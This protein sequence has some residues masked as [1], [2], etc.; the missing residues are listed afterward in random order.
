[1][2]YH[3][4]SQL[5]RARS[6][7]FADIPATHEAFS[8]Y[9]E[10]K[11]LELFAAVAR[12]CAVEL[13]EKPIQN[14][15]LPKDLQ[16]TLFHFLSTMDPLNNL[17]FYIPCLQLLQILLSSSL[18]IVP[19]HLITQLC[20]FLGEIKTYEIN[21]IIINVSYALIDALYHLALSRRK[22]SEHQD[23]AWIQKI[24]LSF[25]GLFNELLSKPELKD[26]AQTEYCLSDTR[27]SIE[28]RV[29]RSNM[30]TDMILYIS[31]ALSK[32][33]KFLTNTVPND[34][35]SQT[36]PLYF[37]HIVNEFNNRP[38]TEIFGVQ[39]GIC[40]EKSIAAFS[41]LN[42]NCALT[43]KL[44]T[45]RHF[46]K[47][48]ADKIR[49]LV[50]FCVLEFYRNKIKT[51]SCC[52]EDDESVLGRLFMQIYE[53]VSNYL[54]H[55]ELEAFPLLLSSIFLQTEISELVT[56]LE[57]SL[58]AFTMQF[59]YKYLSIG[60]KK[61]KL[62]D[63]GLIGLLF[64]NN[65]FQIDGISEIGQAAKETWD[66]I[67]KYLSADTGNYEWISAAV[68]RQ[69]KLNQSDITYL[70]KMNGWIHEQFESNPML[71]EL[72]ISNGLL[73]EMFE[74]IVSLHT[75]SKNSEFLT[76]F[77][78]MV[79]SIICMYDISIPSEVSEKLV[80]LMLQESLIYD[81]SISEYVL[82]CLF[83]LMRKE[84]TQSY[85]R[86]VQMLKNGKTFDVKKRLLEG[87]QDILKDSFY[88]KT[89]Q[90]HFLKAG[91]LKILREILEG[92]FEEEQTDLIWQSTMECVRFVIQDNSFS[93]E[94]FPELGID[95]LAKMISDEKN[96]EKRPEICNKVI[97]ILLLILFDCRNL[98][99]AHEIVN[100]K[101]IPLLLTMLCYVYNDFSH[102]TLKML[103]KSYNAGIFSMNSAVKILVEGLKHS[104]NPEILDFIQKA[105]SKTCGFH[106]SPLD[107]KYVM[108]IACGLNLDKQLMLFD[109]LNEGISKCFIRNSEDNNEKS[110]KFLLD[111]CN[112]ILFS[113]G[114]NTLR[115]EA[116]SFDFLPKKDFTIVLQVFIEK[117]KSGTIL[118]FF[119][120]K[121]EFTVCVVRKSLE[122]VYMC[123]KK[124]QFK[125]QTDKVIRKGEWNFICICMQLW[126]K[127]I[128]S[129]SSL[130][131]IVNGKICGK[132]TEG[133]IINIT[134]GFNNLSLGN[135]SD[136]SQSFIGRLRFFVILNKFL[137]DFQFVTSIFDDLHLIFTPEP[138]SIHQNL[139]KVP[140][141]LYKSVHFHYFTHYTHIY[142]ENIKIIKNAVLFNGTNIIH[143]LA[144]LGGLPLIV[145][146]IHD[147]LVDNSLILKIL[148]FVEIFTRASSLEIL[149]PSDFFEML[150][151]MLENIVVP[152]E[153]LL[154]V[155]NAMLENLSWKPQYREQVFFS[156]LCNTEFWSNLPSELHT[157]YMSIISQHIT[158]HIQCKLANCA[159]LYSHIMSLSPSHSSYLTD[160]FTR[161]LPRGG[162][163][164]NS[165]NLDAVAFLLFK[166]IRDCPEAMEMFLEELS[167]VEIDKKCTSDLIFLILHFMEWI[168]TPSVQAGVLRVVKGIMVSMV[169]EG[170]KARKNPLP[171][172]IL[173]FALN[174]IDTKLDKSLSL[175]IFQ[176]LMDIVIYS[177]TLA[178]T[179]DANFFIMFIDII[180]KRF[181]VLKESVKE[182]LYKATSDYQFC[183]MIVERENFPS[184]LIEAYYTE[185]DSAVSLGLKFFAHSS[186]NM[187][188]QKLRHFVLA[189][190]KNE[191]NSGL[192]FYKQV[193]HSVMNDKFIAEGPRFLDFCSI[194][195]DILNPEV[196][197]KGE[198]NI[199]LLTSVINCLIQQALDLSFV[200]CTYPPLPRMD[201]TLQ[202]ELLKQ[203]PLELSKTEDYI[204]LKEGGFLRLALKY[205]FIGLQISP[206]PALL[207]LLKTVLNAGLNTQNFL[208]LDLLGK[209]IS[210]K[211]L[212]DS[213]CERY[214]ITYSK[215]PTRETELM[216][217]EEFLY[218]YILTELTE[219]VRLSND[220]SLIVF[221]MNFLQD[222][223]I[224]KTLVAWGKKITNK[225]LEDFYKM[226][227]EYKFLFFPNSRSRSPQME[228]NSVLMLMNKL[229]PVSL[230]VFQTHISEQSEML[231]KAKTS[232][233]MLKELFSSTNWLM[234]VYIYIL[235]FTSMKLNFVSGLV[236]SHII[237]PIKNTE[238]ILSED[239]TYKLNA[240]IITKQE[241]LKIWHG[242]FKET[243][244]RLKFVFHQKFVNTTNYFNKTQNAFEKGKVKLR[245]NMDLLSRM[246]TCVHQRHKER[247]ST[248]RSKTISMPTE[249]RF[250][251]S[252]II[253]TSTENSIS[254]SVDESEKGT[255][256][257]EPEE[258]LAENVIIEKKKTVKVEC[259][260]IKVSYSLYGDLEVAQDYILFISEGKEKP[261]EGKYFGSALKFTQEQKKQAKFFIVE[262]IAEVFHRRFIHKH[263][264]FEV[265]LK[266][267]KSLFFNVFTSETRESVFEVIKS[268]KH[269]RLISEIC[270]SYLKSIT[271]KWKRCL[272]SNLE[273]LMI[274]NKFASRSFNDISQYPIFPW[275]LKDYHSSELRL[276]DQHMYRNF[277][278]PIGAQNDSG[279]QEADRRFSMWI[280]EQPYHFGS[281]YS[282]G[283]IVL[284][285]LVRLEP[286]ST[287]AKILQ[288]GKFDIADRLFHSI[289]A[290]WES[291]QG[292][293]GDVKELVP[294]MFYLPEILVNINEEDFGAKQD[295]EE[296]DCVELPRWASSPIDFIRKHR[297]AL[298]SNYVS[299]NINNW[300]DLVFGYKQKG[301]QAQNSYNLFCPMTYEDNFCKM[302]ESSAESEAMMQGMVDQVVHF[303]QTPIRL[304]KSPHTTRDPKPVDMNIFDKYRKF[305]ECV[306]NGCETN[307]EI[308]AL[309]VTTKFL[310]LIKNVY[311]RISAIRI[312]LN[313][314]DNNRVVFERKKE[315]I[316]QG[317]QP[318][319]P[320]SQEFY[321]T[322][323]ENRLVSGDQIDKSFKIHSL[324]G[325]LEA[326]VFGHTDLV[327]S[328]FTI[329]DLL[330]TG[331][332][333]SSLFS[334]SEVKSQDKNLKL[335]L[336]SRFLGH[337]TSIVMIRGLENYQMVFSLGQNG[338][339]LIH[340]FRSSDC[341]KGIKTSAIG[342]CLS[343]LGIIGIYTHTH[344]QFM[345]INES[346]ISKKRFTID[347]GMFDNS[348][349]N[350][351]YFY[352]CTWGFFS[353]FDE[354][355]RFEK[356]EEL[357][358]V[359]LQLPVENEYFIFSQASEKLSYAITF[360]L[361]YKESFRVVRRH[362]IL[363]D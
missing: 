179:E 274:L 43:A 193:L 35:F 283:A 140:K 95:A 311:G 226:V 304:F 276:E 1:M 308:C 143:S 50:F 47:Y 111:T 270:C 109:G 18:F 107:L 103:E 250:K 57:P 189:I 263:T 178:S 125:V 184:W 223:N 41:L 170:K 61:T 204:Y 160:F 154:E 233:A 206:A 230:G 8:V 119:E 149:I 289:Q 212:S 358:L 232:Q 5:S 113:G 333:D 19:S 139:D 98:E 158:S 132:K 60:L 352:G 286:F 298:E 282:S 295:D 24:F 75:S 91:L 77:F 307:G 55:S 323:G 225:E 52:F 327:S 46:V 68:V 281:H 318:S 265:F 32:L 356:T 84:N 210:D 40:F 342:I 217:T 6:M 13:N 56:T 231:T 220:E 324:N 320:S 23:S 2:A 115:F 63:C 319:R 349:E 347:K 88:K 105:L 299:Q 144:L 227:S 28:S 337:S 346:E 213:Q 34:I 315:K 353:L 117:S 151:S 301:K 90:V 310:I 69:I 297:L 14:F 136:C 351:Y 221:A 65:F 94:K 332:I 291:G 31:V 146:I 322:Y 280:D 293:N 89:C 33:A 167:L 29:I 62:S 243:E 275:V 296:V 256:I 20:L 306:S 180:T 336:A 82:T 199:E 328:V 37:Q 334:W 278:L 285:Y 10:H 9:S 85:N 175:E 72:Y 114:K 83:L 292:I 202:Y 211:L 74:G 251:A 317:C 165:E 253:T 277:K 267:G 101:I 249:Q 118:S 145:S 339:I 7:T 245:W 181:A 39:L 313:E 66:L 134:N 11:S 361:I 76:E 234:R 208:V 102:F 30:Y 287:Q 166:M 106:I 176:A 148:K 239:F 321:C 343:N 142:P 279:R 17:E 247:F 261:L 3:D 205:I 329:S 257:A 87:I 173:R 183:A 269:V 357:S 54:I 64:S 153:D 294:E 330:F 100:D 129:V 209:Q 196:S 81:Q 348:G 203:K 325:Q 16:T 244:E 127:I 219:L 355:K 338:D 162:E 314:L 48:Q 126:N 80:S 309:L 38:K 266:S 26:L 288:G 341:I 340:D 222:T 272:I 12:T 241:E 36:L 242:N 163:K 171:K 300:I 350:F 290:S 302:M 168:Q 354:H 187:F 190:S 169:T 264:A 216:F 27:V 258:D 131:V 284:H 161:I 268:W 156:M 121:T 159:Y 214:S 128:S 120:G 79:K 344:L 135:N 42:T 191:V 104:E 4:R 331:S 78:V 92:S 172:D 207:N 174:V 246:T 185:P 316:L 236:K 73:E 363:Q 238:L 49:I 141:D 44:D 21:P 273:Y 200:H 248:R 58:Q 177:F 51:S 152:N 93:Q 224:E 150:S 303:G 229:I 305:G 59:L 71:L 240:F 197:G 53:L 326:S 237:Q 96:K 67:W 192:N 259:E 97:E 260:R 188:I 116:E 359:H 271:K 130:E 138:Y 70:R 25:T 112:F 186:C 254:D 137:T 201:F 108:N 147:N 182:E 228:R 157:S 252:I 164:F 255:Y 345:T 312:S 122:I 218:L 198:I 360:E 362:N 155:V 45:C 124:V 235:A 195:E 110:P 22:K 123:D 133:K 262:E 335:K 99:N 15:T 194:V 86:Y 215:F